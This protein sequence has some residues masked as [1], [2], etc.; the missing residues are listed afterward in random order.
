MS[1]SLRSFM[2]IVYPKFKNVFVAPDALQQNKSCPR[3]K[4]VGNHCLTTC[5][6]I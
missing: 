6:V 2:Y 3:S 5:T 1:S 4:K